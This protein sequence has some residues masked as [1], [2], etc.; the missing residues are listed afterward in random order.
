MQVHY[1]TNR[2][3]KLFRSETDLNREYG[4]RV[5]SLIRARV[6]TLENASDLSQV[7]TK[8][9]ERRHQLTQN[10]DEQY[11]VAIHHQL[12]LVFEPDHQPVPRNADG[13]INTDAVTAIV[14]IAVIDYH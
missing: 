6:A 4:A 3:R 7:S 12:R 11:A 9:P 5:A 13:G 10:R 8:P 2:L 1:K 14:I